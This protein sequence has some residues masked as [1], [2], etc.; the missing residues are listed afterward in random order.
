MISDGCDESGKL[1]GHH[2]NGGMQLPALSGVNLAMIST[3]ARTAS[4]STG[5]GICLCK[6]A[7]WSL[8]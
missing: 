4:H 7:Q 5:I 2:W 3:A 8:V 6:T 1:Y